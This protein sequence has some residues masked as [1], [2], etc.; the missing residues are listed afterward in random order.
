MDALHTRGAYLGMI[1]AYPD[2]VPQGRGGRAGD[3]DV[4]SRLQQTGASVAVGLVNFDKV[5]VQE[6]S[7]CVELVVTMEPSEAGCH[8]GAKR[9][10]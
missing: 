6:V 7:F 9:R 1:E 2:A 8:N 3:E 10:T 4:F 5:L